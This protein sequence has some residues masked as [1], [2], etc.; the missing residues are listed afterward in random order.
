VRGQA[1]CV[2][3][4]PAGLLAEVRRAVGFKKVLDYLPLDD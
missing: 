1:M 2:K 4:D 3:G